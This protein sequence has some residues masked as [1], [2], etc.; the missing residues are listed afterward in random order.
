MIGR[1]AG[2]TLRQVGSVGRLGGKSLAALLMARWT[3]R[4]GLSTERSRSNWILIEQL[5]RV[6]VEVI[7]VIPEIWP[8]RRSN[9]AAREEATVC[10]SAPGRLALTEIT[11]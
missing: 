1:S 4:A 5:P 7:S 6:L 3:S 10:G 2:L 9:G 8:R 11:G